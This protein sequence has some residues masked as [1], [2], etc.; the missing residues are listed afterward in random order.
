MDNGTKRIIGTI[1]AAII[2]TGICV[3]AVVGSLTGRQ[4]S[5]VSKSLK[6]HQRRISE[7]N[8]DVIME[9]QRLLGT[10]QDEYNRHRED[11][12]DVEQALNRVRRSLD[13]LNDSPYGTARRRIMLLHKIE[14][15]LTEVRRRLPDAEDSAESPAGTPDEIQEKLAEIL[16]I[17]RRLPGSENS[18]ESPAGTQE[19]PGESSTDQTSS[20]A[21]DGAAAAP[22]R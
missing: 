12:E 4:V 15:E 5:H 10:L 1:V 7:S 9:V 8:S 21:P 3:G 18:A 2:A 13:A 11:V 20:D 22:D 6:D 19:N 16:D 17:L 14:R